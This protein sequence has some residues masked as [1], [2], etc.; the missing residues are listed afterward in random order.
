[1]ADG[2]TL[3]IV[4]YFDHP[5]DVVVSN[6]N[7]NCCDTPKPGDKVG[8][9]QPDGS[10]SM[11]YVRTDGHG[12]NGRQGQFTLALNSTQTVFMNFDS[13]GAMAPIAPSPGFGA[14]LA[15]NPDGTYSLII[16]PSPTA[17]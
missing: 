4:N 14:W 8:N 13:H 16:G 12:C 7:F 10:A 5:V 11:P 9:I 6:E 15:Q 17:G 3:H 1:M 2:N